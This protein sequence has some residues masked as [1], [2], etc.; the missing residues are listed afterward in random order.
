MPTLAESRSD[1]WARHFVGLAGEEK[2]CAN[3]QLD[4]S[5]Q[6]V[7]VQTYCYLLEA[8]GQI[9]GK[10]VL[11]CGFGTGEIARICE[12]LGGN[13]DAIDLVAT[14]I[15]QLRSQSPNIRWS[16]ADLGTWQLPV[17]QGRYD[18]ILACEV[19]QY[20]DF[21]AVVQNLT[22]ALTE[23]GRL[24]IVIPNANCD[25]VKRSTSRFDNQYLGVD[26]GNL[27]NRLGKYA[28]DFHVSYRGIRF[29]RDQTVVPY[30]ADAWT[31]IFP[32]GNDRV[33]SS[34]STPANRLQI[35]LSRHKRSDGN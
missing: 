25:I 13:V 7:A 21:D 8:C 15:P 22:D 17:N 29:Q 14:R 3:K 33:E 10:H 2:K 11:D 16:S 4:F 9:A 6:A 24:I 27:V 18:I 31:T 5:N 26:V 32:T 19:L 34:Q 20:V 35:V 1:Y 12:L 23:S 28:D 30:A